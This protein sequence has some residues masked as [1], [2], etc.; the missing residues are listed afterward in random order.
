M[1]SIKRGKPFD[2]IRALGVTPYADTVRRLNRKYVWRYPPGDRRWH[3][4]A[5]DIWLELQFGWKP[6]LEDIDG[7][8]KHLASLPLED[9]IYRVSA[10][11]GDLENVNE[12]SRIAGSGSNVWY[13]ITKHSRAYRVESH[14]WYRLSSPA[15]VAAKSLGFT[16]PMALAWDALPLSFVVDWFLP[17]GPW[18][19]T[20]DAGLGL[21]F[22]DG[23]KYHKQEEHWDSSYSGT[24][25]YSGCGGRQVARKVL[26]DRVKISGFP[27]YLPRGRFDASPWRVT[28]SLALLAQAF[29][30]SK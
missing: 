28:T 14:L 13:R 29:G 27:T 21:T 2:A 3:A 30:G 11:V 23:Y 18:L 10:A 16:N 5:G 20:L 9:R 15:I 12:M 22:V 8:A 24:G 6:L 26:K 19:N 17:I 1:S 4:A 7:M 25:Q